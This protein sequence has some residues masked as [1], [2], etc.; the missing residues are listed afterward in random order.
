[1]EGCGEEGPKTGLLQA[2]WKEIPIDVDSDH[3]E[4]QEIQIIVNSKKKMLEERRKMKDSTSGGKD[5]D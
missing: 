3:V 1:V 4:P 2:T 5:S